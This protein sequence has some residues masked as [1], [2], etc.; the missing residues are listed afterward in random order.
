MQETINRDNYELFLID[1][2]EGNL[3]SET[4]AKVLLFLE[5]N[6]D[7]AEE[8]DGISDYDLQECSSSYDEK[9]NLKIHFKDNILIKSENYEHYFIAYYENDLSNDEKIQVEDFIENNPSLRKEF[10]LCKKLKITSNS[11]IT[12]KDSNNLQMLEGFGLS[13]IRKDIFEQYCIDY[14]EGVL[15]S[16]TKAILLQSIEKS[17]VLKKIFTSYTNTY[18]IANASIV[19]KNKSSLYRR[20]FIGIVPL[21]QY[22]SS[23]AAVAAL[24]IIFN[25]SIE[26][27][28]SNMPS[29]DLNPKITNSIESNKII[30]SPQNTEKIKPAKIKDININKSIKAKDKIVKPKTSISI[31]ERSDNYLQR[32]ALKSINIPADNKVI[33]GEELVCNPIQYFVNDSSYFLVV[34]SNTTPE[35]D[36]GK[37]PR[38]IKKISSKINRVYKQEKENL[39][40]IPKD[41][42]V[43]S[44]A[45]MAIKGF[46]KLTE[47]NI[48][49]R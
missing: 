36:I 16:K 17:Q 15:N 34:A 49:L 48:A 4:H 2:M 39:S 11:N 47:G 12:F 42:A 38:G 3:D 14:H 7:I 45:N 21:K 44:I 31:Q 9:E 5:N 25:L 33:I 22:I 8:F 41:K 18:F 20:R 37:L 1:F 26:P 43:K 19:F 13:E 32:V 28:I 29:S 24:L 40:Q 23:V 6:N 46:N 10:E 35:T 27:T 30:D